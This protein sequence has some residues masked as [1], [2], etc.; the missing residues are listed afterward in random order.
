[1]PVLGVHVAQ[2]LFPEDISLQVER[3]NPI[4]SEEG[5]DPFAVSDGGSG[6]IAAGIMA[7]L[8]RDAV[9]HGFLPGDLPV[10][11]VDCEYDEL[12]LPHLEDIVM[13]AGPHPGWRRDRRAMG[14]GSGEVDPVSPDHG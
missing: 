5:I 14:D 3:E 9:P 7:T 12:H 2:V 1:M 13:R 6:G 11:A 4:G 10:G 8:V